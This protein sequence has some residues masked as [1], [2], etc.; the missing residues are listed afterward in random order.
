[1]FNKR[2]PIIT[3]IF[4][5]LFVAST[6]VAE[7]IADAKE[8]RF[9]G[10]KSGLKSKTVDAALREI[11]TK[12]GSKFRKSSKSSKDATIQ[13]SVTSQWT[14]ELTFVCDNGVKKNDVAAT[15][16]STSA[17]GNSGT[18]TSE[19]TLVGAPYNTNATECPSNYYARG[20]YEGNYQIIGKNI[21]FSEVTC[22]N[23]D[24]GGL[25]T[26]DNDP[27]TS[28][29]LMPFAHGAIFSLEGDTLTLHPTVSE[30]KV[31]VLQR[32]P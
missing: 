23:M 17:D 30:H 1:M 32:M 27:S 24:T 28:D 19:P 8:I 22:T 6:G 5:L 13:D 26:S 11:G 4:S 9:S 2:L 31:V 12:L 10:K 18:F 3:F 7:P 16:I 20:Q 29:P 15:F 21:Y 25:C 14:G